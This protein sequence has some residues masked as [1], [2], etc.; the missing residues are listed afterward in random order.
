MGDVLVNLGHA[1]AAL[2]AVFAAERGPDRAGDA[3]V[4][5]VE[6]PL[7]EQL[8]D[9][10]LLLGDAVH[11]GYETG[12][13]AHAQGVEVGAESGADTEDDVE[14]PVRVAGGYALSV[15]KRTKQKHRPRQDGRYY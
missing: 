7:P 9:D 12:I 3:E 6:L 11:L 8:V 14:P 5:I 4:G 13:G 1:S 15:W 10:D 2:L